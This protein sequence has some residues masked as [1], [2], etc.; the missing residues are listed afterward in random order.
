MRRISEL[1]MSPID[2]EGLKA[3]GLIVVLVITGLVTIP[4]IRVLIMAFVLAVSSPIGG[5][6]DG[7]GD[8]AHPASD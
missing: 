4:V 6:M 7:G 8:M 5:T 3:I 1:W 2:W